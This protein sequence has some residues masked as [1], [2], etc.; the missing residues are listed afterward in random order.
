MGDKGDKRKS[1]F[2]FNP[3][4]QMGTDEKRI[5]K[6][7]NINGNENETNTTT[8]AETT[9]SGLF[10]QI[11][12]VFRNAETAVENRAI[13]FEHAVFEEIK[14]FHEIFEAF[15]D[16]ESKKYQD[17]LKDKSL[18]PEIENDVEIRN[19]KDLCR[20]EKDFLKERKEQIK[21]SFAKYV[22]VNIE[23]IDVDDI[24]VI[25][26]A[27]SG[28]GF[29]AMIANAAFLRATQ[30]SGLYDCGIYSAGVSG[31]C[32]SIA[33]QYTSLHATKSNPVQNLLDHLKTR[34]TVELTFGGLFEKKYANLEERIIDIFGSLLAVKLL[35]G[36]D[37]KKDPNRQEP[38]EDL[39]SQDFKLS[40]QKRYLEGGTRMM[41]IYTSV[42]EGK[43]KPGSEDVVVYDWYEFTPFEIGSDKYDA[44]IPTWAFGREF[45]SG[46]S[47]NNSPEQNI[48]QLLGMFGSAPCAPLKNY[49]ETFKDT[50]HS[51]WTKDKVTSLGREFGSLLG[52]NM[53][54]EIEDQNLFHPAD[55]YYHGFDANQ[56]KFKLLDSGV[57]DDLP[58]YPLSRP[59]RE[60]DII[61]AFDTSGTVNKHKKFEENQ[62]RHASYRGIKIEERDV[63]SKY[64]E[65]YNYYLPVESK[66]DSKYT[67]HLCTF[68]YIPYLPNDKVKKI[69]KVNE[70]FNPC[71]D[72]FMTKFTYS[73]EEVNLMISLA[74]K[75]WL[76]AAEEKVKPIIIET[77]KK[78]RDARIARS[79][80]LK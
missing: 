55:N 21:S 76:E 2:F 61:I 23:E 62:K 51:G 52:A 1:W 4:S 60:V 64:C 15:K 80:N 69:D 63:K 71:K 13:A 5:G 44:W 56:L 43:K 59:N 74:E 50:I 28:G 34:L 39:Q 18:H 68:F 16:L 7:N 46:K 47:I 10:N 67:A 30:S 12:N 78:K 35:L 54:D 41:P 31:G 27:G 26:F 33:Q 6:D 20:E 24:P 19:S 70:N 72:F 77:W 25:A 66:D 40:H 8:T 49:L 73:E 32:L 11:M 3:F 75:N 79:K 29:R 14:N 17:K 58:L 36:K 65:I 37:P 48:S 22:G 9:K 45:K 53:K 38:G 57:S 42:E